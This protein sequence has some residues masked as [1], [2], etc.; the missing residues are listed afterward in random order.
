MR[1][2]ALLL[3]LL[4]LLAACA[5]PTEPA[6][7]PDP[8]AAAANA[9]PNGRAPGEPAAPADPAPEDAAPPD[10]A[11]AGAA[12]PRPDAEQMAKISGWLMDRYY[13]YYHE[14][15]GFP[16][17]YGGS[18]CDEDKALVL[19][20]TDTSAAVLDEV[21]AA[22]C[23]DPEDDTPPIVD[24]WFHTI[25]YE[26]VSNSYDAMY[27][28]HDRLRTALRVVDCGDYQVTVS[29]RHNR[30]VVFCQTELAASIANAAAGP[31]LL[32][33]QPLDQWGEE[34]LPPGAE[35]CARPQRRPGDAERMILAYTSQHPTE[36][37]ITLPDYFA[38][39]YLDGD[40]LVLCLTDLSQQ[41]L[42]WVRADFYAS[43]EGTAFLDE[44]LAA[45]R[46]EQVPYS[47]LALKDGL[48]FVRRN[49]EWRGCRG[50][51]VL[52]SLRC[53]QVAVFCQTANTMA[54]ARELEPS[55][56]LAVLP[57]GQ[58][59]AWQDYTAQHT[60]RFGRAAVPPLPETVAL[61]AS[62]E[63]PPASS[64]VSSILCGLISDYESRCL[65][66]D[67][68]IPVYPD[69]FSG[70]YLDG[71]TL[72]LCLTDT[73][74]PVR[75]E[76]CAAFLH[77]EYDFYRRTHLNEWL[78]TVRCRQVPYSLRALETLEASLSDALRGYCFFTEIRVP[79]NQLAVYCPEEAM[80]LARSCAEAGSEDA[81][82]VLPLDALATPRQTAAIPPRTG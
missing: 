4:L 63:P 68:D 67:S 74:E 17:Y 58:R 22:F 25:R 13:A 15:G 54:Q 33:I 39:F 20:L 55:D 80:A 30:V 27:D 81:L 43:G 44:Q 65:P 18:Y 57:I 53:N 35:D 42:E 70:F 41:T 38:G 66:E 77:G 28:L 76:I 49:L 52:L 26:R 23:G 46:V 12:P 10:T 40:T 75:G 72:V 36:E 73:S 31:A 62:G 16:D 71:D 69:Y 6:A 47:Y 50:Y 1:R 2:I 51:D 21:R 78:P 5:A 34:A 7:G 64:D 14:R 29:L 60:V 48:Q 32:W 59:E 82:L 3:A 11:E 56:L 61:T 37:F 9:D 19:C 45:M 24:K 79:D 8:G